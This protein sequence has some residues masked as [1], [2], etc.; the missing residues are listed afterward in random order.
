M[1]ATWR[2]FGY[3]T[4]PSPK[5]SVILIKA[6]LP[7]SVKFFQDASKV[8][9]LLLYFNRPQNLYHIKYCDFHN[10]FIIS[11]KISNTLLKES[12][13]QF[14]VNIANCGQHYYYKRDKNIFDCITRMKM[15]YPH[16]SNPNT[17]DQETYHTRNIKCKRRSR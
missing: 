10:Q 15:L 14:L 12:R 2:T 9:K 13:E 7:E 3:C 5:P 6:M 1:D 16:N 8:T 4:Y 11:V 17:I